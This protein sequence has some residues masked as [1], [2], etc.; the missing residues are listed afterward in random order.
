MALSYDENL[1]GLNRGVTC[2]FITS[3][4]VSWRTL[5]IKVEPKAEGEFVEVPDQGL[6][7]RGTST[8]P[9][10]VRGNI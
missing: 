3:Y 5:I 10:K 4:S 7:I 8:N 1:G 6:Q 2:P 9:C